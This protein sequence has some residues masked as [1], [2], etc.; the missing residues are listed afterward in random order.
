L[1]D[2]PTDL[3]RRHRLFDGTE[4]TIRPIRPSDAQM[5][6][7]FVRHL[8]DDSRYFR[9][10]AQLHELPPEKLKF[11]TEVDHDRHLA[12]VA[13]LERA[14]NE[15][16]IGVARYV[17]SPE[18]N[19]C[20]FAI[21]VDDAWQGSGVAGIL[22]LALINA[23]RSRGLRRMEGYVLARNHKMLKFARQLGFTVH[24]RPPGD[25]TVMVERPL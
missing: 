14:G 13:T 23:A 9:F 4:I 21:A 20:E 25:D 3:V 24:A 7:A 5:E 1:A 22:M 19:T 2:Y 15:T 8:S 6:Q 11:F 16:E 17:A 10:M 18:G 12:L